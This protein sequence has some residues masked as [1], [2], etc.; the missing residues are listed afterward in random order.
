VLR[1]NA[2]QERLIDGLLTL[3]R[4]QA[5]TAT[6]EAVD[7][8]QIADELVTLREH[9]TPTLTWHT[10]LRPAVVRGDPTLLERLVANLLDNASAYNVPRDG[11][12]EVHTGQSGG[13]PTLC[14]AN[15]G[16]DIAQDRVEELFEPFR[17][18]EGERLAN[19]RGFGLGLSIVR[20][21]ADASGATIDARPRADGGL[22]LE[23]TFPLA[24]Q[25]PEPRRPRE[26]AAAGL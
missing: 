20:A 17:R 8:R 26:G 10:D 23:I 4:G 24:G 16:A 5:G 21:I 14:V 25:Q 19:G 13:H 6:A 3:A 18:L 1:S 22:E 9:E 11:W 12:I 7:L 2:Q 15:A